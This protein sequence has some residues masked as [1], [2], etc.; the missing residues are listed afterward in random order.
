M[1]ANIILSG[2]QVQPVNA[3][4][5]GALAGQQINDFN[6]KNDM[7]SM[8]RNNGAGILA[9]DQ[10]ALNALAGFDPS[11]AQ[12]IQTGQLNQART[13]QQM[14][15][16]DADQ[17]RAIE[18]QA[19]QMSAAERQATA[20]R[21]K[22]AVAS[23]LQAQTP[24]QWDSV[25]GSMAPDLVGQFD[26]REMIAAQYMSVADSLTRFDERN[27]APDPAKPLTQIAKLQADLAAGLITQ[28][29]YDLALQNMA[30]SG[31][32]IKSDGQGGFTM[33][34]GPGVTGGDALPTLTVDAAKNA[35][36]LER[37]R[38]TAPIIDDLEQQGLSFGQ[39]TAGVIPGGLGN[40]VRTPEFQKYDQA[41]RDFVNA[42][43]RRESGAVISDSEF[44]NA[45]AQYFPVPGDSP[46]VIAQKRGNRAA[47]VRG[48]EI[49][50]GEGVSLVSPPEPAQWTAQTIEAMPIDQLQQSLQGLDFSVLSD[51]ALAAIEVK[52]GGR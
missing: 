37:L 50:A 22:R 47:A 6:R 7:R 17:Q 26:N 32:I 10:N 5:Q 44:A 19:A 11:A 15:A 21:I 24:E 12:S 23:G 48:V 16:F 30:P 1:S 9:G 18:A 8:L 29:Q 49:G 41:R 35:G 38:T 42:I 28:P 13:R 34:Q 43:L 51:E 36:F 4:A 39:Q 45:E 14:A 52:M 46:E 25:V 40:F 27:A 2:Q 31:T 33:A 20:D 3:L